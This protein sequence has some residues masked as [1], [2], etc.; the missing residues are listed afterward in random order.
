MKRHQV[1]ID[2]DRCVGCG[3][4]ERTCPAH[5]LAIQDRKAQTRLED[6][7]MCG[8]CVAVCPKQAVSIEGCGEAPA[9]KRGEARLDPEEV[10]DVI[11]FRRSV[12]RFAQREIP[13]EALE[14]ILE[15]GRL[16][17]TAK[18]AQDLSFVVLEGEKDRIEK[19]AVGL[20]RRIKPFADRF[21]PMAR[22]RAVDDRFFF[23]GAPTA[24]VILAKDRTNGI[25]AAQ[26]MEFVAEAQGLGVLY[27]GFF[28]TAVNA[29]RKIK[30]AIHVPGGKR[31]AM[32]L[33]LGY[34]DVRF[35][36]AAPREALDVR[37]L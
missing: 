24:I 27:S 26:N 13:R 31:A 2:L 6:C 19:M 34:P 25:L 14:R 3:L 4:C 22:N 20:F 17:H 28:T 9:E 10:L 32:T 29:S 23:F 12:R 7:L 18:N 1:K 33:V 30:K 15:A 16:T 36:R 5:A 35:L 8:H 11:R 21:S 37:Y